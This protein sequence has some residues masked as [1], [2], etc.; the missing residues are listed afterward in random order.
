[1][2]VKED[3]RHRRGG[4]GEGRTMDARKSHE[5]VQVQFDPAAAQQ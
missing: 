4:G 5:E 1:M 3:A 2:V